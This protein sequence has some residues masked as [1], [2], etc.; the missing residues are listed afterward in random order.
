[1]NIKK[2]LLMNPP[3]SNEQRYGKGISRIGTA[4]HPLGLLYIAAVLEKGGY[5][6]EV[7]DAPVEGLDETSTVEKIKSSKPDLIGIYTNTSNYNAVVKLSAR[8]KS[9]LKTRI[10]L[11]GPQ[12]AINQ[13]ESLSNAA[14]DFIVHGEAEFAILDLCNAVNCNTVNADSAKES[15][16]NKSLLNILLNIKGLGFKWEEQTHVN[17]PADKIKDLD[18]LPYPARHLID[19][20]LYRP[21]PNHYTKLPH[22]NMTASRGCPFTCT[23]CSSA[24][25]WGHSYRIRSVDNVIGEIRELVEKHGIRSI[26]FWD[27]I[28]GIR[29]AWIHEFCEKVIEQKLDFEWW[30]LLRADLADL[31]TLKKMKAAG[32]WSIFFGIET[33]DQELLDS[34]NK[35]TTVEQNIAAIRNT[36][37]AGIQVRANFIVGLPNETPE[38]LKKTVKLVCKLNPDYVKFNVMSPYPGT[39]LYDEIKQGKWGEMTEET[40]KL[41]GYFAT[42]R[43]YGYK[44]FDELNKMRKYA[45]RKFYFRPRYIAGRLASIRSFEDIKRYWDGMIAL[46]GL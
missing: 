32:C 6:V 27:D 43:P 35:R 1:M 21:S 10:L 41:T 17:P 23:F 45:F 36:K 42:F 44:D 29:K 37:E 16:L 8:I 5:S 7:L 4:L 18:S 40:D 30:C 22:A 28:F 11:G 38:K 39:K 46:V 20:S 25:I 9:G 14:V 34:I 26:S 15:L 13:Q 12:T 33:L 24:D 31:E 3:F 2:V 19:V